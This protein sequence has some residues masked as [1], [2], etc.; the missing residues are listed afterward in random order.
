MLPILPPGSTALTG[1][2]GSALPGKR[3]NARHYG[4]KCR[5]FRAFRLYRAVTLSVRE[6]KSWQAGHVHASMP[7]Q[8]KRRQS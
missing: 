3:V 7:A 6:Q 4:E 1:F 8:G 5:K 2:D